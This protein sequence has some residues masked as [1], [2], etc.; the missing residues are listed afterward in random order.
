M[1]YPQVPELAKG[2]DCG[3]CKN[4]VARPVA[5]KPERIAKMPP[6]H[7]GCEPYEHM[8]ISSCLFDSFLVDVQ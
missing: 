1:L 5:G 7:A 6:F 8:N 4:N 3:D 2:V